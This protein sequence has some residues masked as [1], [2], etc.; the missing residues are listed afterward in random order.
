MVLS[1]EMSIFVLKFKD[2]ATGNDITDQITELRVSNG[3]NTSIATISSPQSPIYVAVYFVGWS[4]VYFTAKIG[5][6]TYYKNPS[7]IIN[8]SHGKVYRYNV[9]VEKQ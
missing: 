5:T 4:P 7:D 3:A 8:F 1:P 2:S 6:D 9:T